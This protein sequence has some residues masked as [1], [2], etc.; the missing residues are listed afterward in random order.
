[1]IGADML[2]RLLLCAAEGGYHGYPAGTV[3]GT[4]QAR[5]RQRPEPGDFVAVLATVGQHPLAVLGVL[6]SVDPP[7]GQDGA[8]DAHAY[9]R[10][11]VLSCLDGVRR[12]WVN[13]R[14]VGVSV[15]DPFAD[16]T[17]V[18]VCP[19]DIASAVR[20]ACEVSGS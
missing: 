15:G 12:S 17:D 7:L 2:A 3:G 19:P 16:P 4:K 1:M 6:E 5:R 9:N 8:R 18:Y 10:R 14:C 13:V 20:R 11:W